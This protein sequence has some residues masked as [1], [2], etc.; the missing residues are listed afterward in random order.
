VDSYACNEEGTQFILATG[1]AFVYVRVRTETIHLGFFVFLQ[2]EVSIVRFV[3]L[4][5][6]EPVA[7]VVYVKRRTAYVIGGAIGRYDV[8]GLV[9]NVVGTRSFR[10]LVGCISGGGC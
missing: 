9:W 3:Y 10:R 2:E 8:I 5:G 6:R 1:D 4:C 7:E